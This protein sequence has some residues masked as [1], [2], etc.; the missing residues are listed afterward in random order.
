M[1]TSPN[2][3][4]LRAALI[5]A[6]AL[7]AASALPAHAQDAAP[8]TTASDDLATQFRDPPATARPRVWWH[9]MNGNITKDGIAKDLA[10][11]KAVGIGGFQN[12]DVNLQTPKIVDHRLAYM[13]PEW[14]DAFRFA[15]SEAERQGLE[16]AIASSPGWSETGGPWVAPEDGL[17]KLVWTETRVPAGRAF[18]GRLPA[19]PSVTGPF[20]SMSKPIG[21]DD[22]ATGEAPKQPPVH[23]GDIAVL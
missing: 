20:Q 18:A 7:C 10:W 19:P 13:T 6:S 16:M 12:F 4:A 9:W 2:A 3:R 11:M 21:L 14:K 1:M 17:K 15:A 8:A 23:Y 22:L 5:A